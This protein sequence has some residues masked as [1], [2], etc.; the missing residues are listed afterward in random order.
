MFDIYLCFNQAVLPT[1]TNFNLF[2]QR[3]APQIYLRYDQMHV[4]LRKL[5][6][7]FVKSTVIAASDITE[8]EYLFTDNQKENYHISAVYW[9]YHQRNDFQKVG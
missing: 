3:D 7:K 5:L 2:L 1:F 4:L 9:N 6:S 8:I